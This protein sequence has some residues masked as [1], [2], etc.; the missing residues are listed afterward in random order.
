MGMQ[1]N[2]VQPGGK[3]ARFGIERQALPGFNQCLGNEVFGR[4]SVARQSGSLPEQAAV[5]RLD[6]PAECFRIS[7]A[8]A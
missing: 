6:Q 2:R 3:P 8:R 7:L 1:Q 4:D 5:Q